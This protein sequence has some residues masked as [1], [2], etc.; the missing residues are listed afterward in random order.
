[1]AF[2][3]FS[4]FETVTPPRGTRIDLTGIARELDR[5]ESRSAGRWTYTGNDSL[6][7]RLFREGESGQSIPSSLPL[8]HVESRLISLFDGRP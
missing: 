5:A 4:W 1:M 6:E 8:A 3:I 7:S 2:Q